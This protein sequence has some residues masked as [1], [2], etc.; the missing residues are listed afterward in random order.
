MRISRDMPEMNTVEFF[1]FIWVLLV[2][3][4]SFW[5]TLGMEEQSLQIQLV[6]Y[7]RMENYKLKKQ[8]CI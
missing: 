8:H 1:N 6:Q 4:Y 5:Q 3:I 7:T 2:C